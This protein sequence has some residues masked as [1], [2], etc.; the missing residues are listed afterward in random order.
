MYSVPAPV[1][2]LL[3]QHPKHDSEL[4]LDALHGQADG[5]KIVVVNNGAHAQTFLA[6]CATPPKVMLLDMQL[7]DMEGIELLR[8]IRSDDR[9]KS[10][11]VLMLTESRDQRKTEARCLGVNGYLPNTTDAGV[12]AEHLTIFRHLIAGD[13]RKVTTE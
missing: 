6:N 1:H 9:T 10:L 8:R 4:T 2:V 7:P 13:R 3:V 5:I 11:P 12:L